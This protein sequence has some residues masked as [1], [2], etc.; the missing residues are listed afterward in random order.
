MGWSR[1]RQARSCTCRRGLGRRS[2]ILRAS[3]AGRS[4]RRY[5]WSTGWP[6]RGLV[7]GEAGPDRRT[8]SLVLTRE[9]SRAADAVLEARATA[10]DSMLSGLPA[11]DKAAL[12]RLLTLVAAGLGTPA[13][14]VTVSRSCRAQTV[15]SK[16][17]RAPALIVTGPREL[18]V[19]RALRVAWRDR[20][21]G[22][23]RRSGFD[24]AR[25]RHAGLVAAVARYQAGSGPEPPG[26]SL[27]PRRIRPVRAARWP[28]RHPGRI[29]QQLHRAAR[30]LGAIRSQRR[31]SRHRRS[32]GAAG[33]AAPRRDLPR[34]HPLRRGQRRHR[35]TRPV[36]PHPRA[37]RRVQSA[38][39]LR[40][41]ALVAATRAMPRTSAFD[42]TDSTRTWHPGAAPPDRRRSTAST[43]SSGRPTPRRTRTSSAR[44]AFRCT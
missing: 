30:A 38:P 26:L 27:R 19:A 31:R 7:R 35:G 21:V 37:R 11:R 12:E 23:L 3:S 41:E 22:G 43:A 33:A 13:G 15:R 34:P 20:A 42:Q 5:G 8:L 16:A 28:G 4:R 32:G 24:R 1:P 10:L 2:S 29:S 44:S 39:R 17:R 36:P 14:C 6:K 40:A 9:R 18:D 25:A